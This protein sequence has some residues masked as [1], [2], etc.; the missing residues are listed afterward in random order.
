MFA[1]DIRMAYDA[2]HVHWGG[3][4]RTPTENEF[5]ELNNNCT[6][7]W[8][9]ENGVEGLRLTSKKAG[10]TDKSIFI[11]ATGER[12]QDSSVDVGSFGYYMSSERTSYSSSINVLRVYNYS[13]G[14]SDTSGGYDRSN[15]FP[16][17]PVCD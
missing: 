7:T 1:R 15:G 10:Y 9:T 12:Y 17:R 2:A 14:F 6:K 11:P 13:N 3:T 16:V 8:T 5:R 4:W